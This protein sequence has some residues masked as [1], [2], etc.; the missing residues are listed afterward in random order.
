MGHEMAHLLKNHLKDVRGN[1]LK[2]TIWDGTLTVITQGLYNGDARDSQVRKAEIEADYVGLY[3]TARAGYD[4]SQAGPF[5]KRLESVSPAGKDHSTGE[6][7]A[8]AAQRTADEIKAQ[9]A[10]GKP[11]EPCL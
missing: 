3:F 8:L 4:I 1:L 6:Q 7:R 5:W 10:A 11:L 9:K 2:N